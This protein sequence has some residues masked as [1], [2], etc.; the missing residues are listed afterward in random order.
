MSAKHVTKKPAPRKQAPPDSPVA[1]ARAASH[2]ATLRLV[3]DKLAETSNKTQMAEE[4][5]MSRR[6]LYRYL[7]ELGVVDIETVLIPKRDGTFRADVKPR[8]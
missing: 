2:A 3:R 1:L 6:T 5:G 8:E 4:L 7:H